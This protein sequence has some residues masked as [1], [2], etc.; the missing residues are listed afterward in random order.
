MVL[1]E[2]LRNEVCPESLLDGRQVPQKILSLGYDET[3][4]AVILPAL[5]LG[6]DVTILGRQASRSSIITGPVG[7][8]C[9]NVDLGTWLP[10]EQH[11]I[12]LAYNV[13]QHLGH[14]YVLEVLLSFLA[15]RL[16]PGGIIDIVVPASK[17]SH[18]ARSWYER[19]E[20]AAALERSHLEFL[21][22]SVLWRVHNTS[23]AIEQT[24]VV[25]VRAQKQDKETT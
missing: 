7:A 13:F 14:D 22:Q 5:H 12:V 18:P 24:H 4:A 21:C 15:L 6:H 10:V 9:P 11:D 17:D 2:F 1:Q 8:H 19:T 3:A 23:G 20:I 25:W 16:N